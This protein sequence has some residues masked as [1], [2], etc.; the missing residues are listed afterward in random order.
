M[1]K[2][3]L[4]TRVSSIEQKSDRQKVNQKEF[5]LTIEDKCSGAVPFFERNG[6]KDI[7]KLVD[8]KTVK[9]ISVWQIDRLGRNL[10]DIMNTLHFFT[11]KQIPIIFESQGL[12]TLDKDGKENAISKMMI[13]ILATIGEMERNQIRERQLEGIRLAKMKGIYKGRQKGSKESTFKFLSKPKNQKAMKYLEQ[14]LSYK[15]VSTLTGL[16]TIT[17]AKVKKL[18][19]QN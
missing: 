16:H 17:I 5:D 4:Y 15:E 6:G 10:R 13:S 3:I 9:S 2:S 14:K 1:S 8:A 11:E 18:M 7:K 19:N 12:R